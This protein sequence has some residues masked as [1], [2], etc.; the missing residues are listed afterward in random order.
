M[1]R[2]R[3]CSNRSNGHSPEFVGWRWV[4]VCLAVLMAAST[5]LY[6]GHSNAATVEVARISTE[7]SHAHSAVSEHDHQKPCSDTGHTY[8]RGTGCALA[9]ACFF[10]V[11][12]DVQLFVTACGAQPAA[13]AP[14]FVSS[15]GDVPARLRPPKAI[16]TA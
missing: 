9:S 3:H 2:K 10:C 7:T 12:V 5:V 4:A 15:P 16:A 11:P 1:D 14:S 13:V 8:H 6:G